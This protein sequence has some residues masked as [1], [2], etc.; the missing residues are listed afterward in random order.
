MNVVFNPADVHFA[1]G[2]RW[3]S[4]HTETEYPVE[5]TVTV[6]LPSGERQWQLMPLLDDQELDTRAG[7]G[8]V[9]WEGAVSADGARGYLELT[10]YFQPLKM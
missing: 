9:Y 1:A 2:R 3:R 8:P 10:G 4:P 6:R 7:G 5:R